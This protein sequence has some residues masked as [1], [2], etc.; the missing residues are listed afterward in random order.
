MTERSVSVREGFRHF[1]RFLGLNLTQVLFTMPF[2]R[3]ISNMRLTTVFGLSMLAILNSQAV[4][5]E[6][7]KG[8]LVSEPNG[9]TPPGEKHSQYHHGN[10][11]IWTGLWPKGR[12]TF[13]S[14][15]PGEVLRNGAMSM[16]W[17]WWWRGVAGRL[18]I[19]GRRVDAPG[20]PLRADIP[21][22]YGESGFQATALIF[23]SEGCWE[24]SGSIGEKEL[25]FVTLV[26]KGGK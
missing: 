2:R 17:W 20:A 6:A 9:Q 19:T 21:E 14:G 15:G 12:V 22:G 7:D 1:C 8:C 3:Q 10:G 5:G 24:V 18:V 16:K 26:V 13:S 23:P 4:R 11:F 25:K